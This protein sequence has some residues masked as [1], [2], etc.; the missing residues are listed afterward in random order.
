MYPN[1]TTNTL[2]L[3]AQGVIKNASIYNVIGKEVL[4]LDINKNSESIDV[5]KLPKGIYLI[6]Y[7]MDDKVGS[8]KFIKR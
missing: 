2:N 3:T 6:K 7:T 5:S 4:C 8:A 1:P